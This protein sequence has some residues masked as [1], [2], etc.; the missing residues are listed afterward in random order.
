[1]RLTRDPAEMFA[2]CA[3]NRPRQIAAE[4]SSQGTARCDDRGMHEDFLAA[5]PPWPVAPRC[6]SCL[7]RFWVNQPHTDQPALVI[8]ALDRISVQLELGDDGSR[9]VNAAGA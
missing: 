6:G 9:E 1:M 8:D 3:P 2:T 4:R 5:W 7:S